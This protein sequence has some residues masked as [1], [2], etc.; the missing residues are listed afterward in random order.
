M[1][2]SSFVKLTHW[3]K[4][5]QKNKTKVEEKVILFSQRSLK[6]RIH[7]FYRG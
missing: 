7:K 3:N 4:E 2:N 5:G 6:R 1:N